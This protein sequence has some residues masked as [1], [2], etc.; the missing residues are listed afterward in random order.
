MSTFVAIDFETA[1]RHRDSAC[2]IGLAVGHERRVVLSRTYLIRPPSSHFIFTGLHGLAWED[3]RDAPTFA[4]L[5][6]MLRSWIDTP[7]FLAAHNAAFD[8]SVLHACCNRYRLPV[9]SLRFICTVRVARSQWRIFPTTLPHVCRR[10]RIG[11]RHHEAGSDAVACA[12]IVLAAEAEGWQPQGRELVQAG[13][14]V[15]HANAI[16]RSTQ[17]RGPTADSGQDQPALSP[18]P[19][20]PEPRPAK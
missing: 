4:D 8:Q 13:A 18:F 1:T 15:S 10:L 20:G 16:V 17:F 2:A 9:P 6:P 12:R 14:R 3:V 19:P 5:W 7:R 11:L